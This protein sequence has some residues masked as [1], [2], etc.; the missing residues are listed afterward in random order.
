MF[1]LSKTDYIIYRH[2]K[3]NAWMKIH[4]P[5]IYN[6]GELSNFEKLIIET[7][8][9]IDQYARKLFPSGVLI[10]GRGVEAEKLTQK[11][12][13]D[14]KRVIFQPVFAKDGFMAAF[15]ILEYDDENDN[16]HIYEVKASS[17]VDK[18]VHL[19]DLAFQVALLKMMGLKVGKA[20]LIHLN[21]WYVR[22]GDID[23][24]KLF[25]IDDMTTEV[26]EISGEV[27][28]E[29][30][31][32]LKYISDNE[33]PKGYCD[34]VYKGRSNHCTTFKYSN[35]QVPDYGVHDISR[36]GS[37]KKKLFELIDSGV[38]HLH[39]ANGRIEF[40]SIQ[41]NQIDAH[42]LDRIQINKIKIAEELESLVFPLYFLDYETFPSAIPRFD[43]FS[44][45]Q[46][47]PFQFSVHILDKNGGELRHEEFLHTYESDPTVSLLEH[48]KK[49]IGSEG[50]IVV[51]NK[52]FE[53]K[54]NEEIAERVPEAREF[55]DDVN[56]RVYDLMDIFTKQHYVH[57][58]F[59]GSTSIKYVLPVMR[60]DLSYK[61]LGIQEGGTASQ[62]WNEM[63]TG[64]LS[65]FEK[66]MI[67]GDLREYCKLDTYA[68][69]AIWN[70]LHESK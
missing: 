23:V 59:K 40:S 12:L 20:S 3:K 6:Q 48:L 57:K 31:E 16:Y 67:E 5:E 17:E 49:Y 47:I 45:Y 33:E 39:E 44:P 15:D 29:M 32:A 25:S 27:E 37:S 7:G 28:R 42:V 13:A 54:I 50:T 41:Q 4:K 36:I 1:Q 18:N 14:K 55:I 68:M 53:C 51:W 8:N 10:E 38:F 64:G 69:Y 61:E 56:S 11:Y 70:E 66:K 2:C 46:Q 63:T 58:D 21:S 62:S 22:K 30:N 24:F 9:E 35:P 60:P 34:C 26:E 43:G 19:Y 52:K 65:D